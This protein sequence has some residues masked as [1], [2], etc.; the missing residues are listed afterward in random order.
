M[1]S[2][3]S[4]PPLFLSPGSGSKVCPTEEPDSSSSDVYVFEPSALSDSVHTVATEDPQLARRPALCHVVC[5]NRVIPN[6]SPNSTA[7]SDSAA[8]S[9][10]TSGNGTN[11]TATD[12]ELL[13][14]VGHKLSRLV[15]CE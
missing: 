14:P 1:L 15:L 2:I 11:S 5:I 8:T 10:P 7:S 3:A 13:M 9:A 4:S 6:I 12:K